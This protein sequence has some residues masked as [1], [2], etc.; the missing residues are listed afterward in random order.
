MPKFSFF[1]IVEQR[2]GKP[3]LSRELLVSKCM[4]GMNQTE[5][6]CSRLARGP[7]EQV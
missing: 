5:A 2:F 4:H 1:T 7:K 3:P 6:E